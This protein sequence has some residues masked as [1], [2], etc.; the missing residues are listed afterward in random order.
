[1]LFPS[2]RTKSSAGKN[3]ISPPMSQAEEE[4][5]LVVWFGHVELIVVCGFEFKLP[6]QVFLEA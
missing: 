4:A 2:R 1:V 5:G 3:S 6:D